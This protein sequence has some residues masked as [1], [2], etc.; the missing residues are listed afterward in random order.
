[1]KISIRIPDWTVDVEVGAAKWKRKN[2]TRRRGLTD[3]LSVVL[4]KAGIEAIERR[5]NQWVIKKGL[6]P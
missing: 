3:D 5:A 1:M 4:H 6:A 2:N